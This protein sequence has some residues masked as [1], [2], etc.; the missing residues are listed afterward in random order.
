MGREMYSQVYS[1]CQQIDVGVLERSD[2]SWRVLAACE[3]G[4]RTFYLAACESG[5]AVLE[6]LF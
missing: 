2:G 5:D 6:Q 3:S 4:V 1:V